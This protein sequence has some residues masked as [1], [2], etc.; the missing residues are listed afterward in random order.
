[1]VVAF[2][3]DLKA[4]LFG[5]PHSASPSSCL[6]TRRV[7]GVRAAVL[8]YF[9][10]DPEHFDVVFVANAT[11]AI[12]LVMHSFQEQKFSYRYHKDAHTSLV[13]IREVATAGSQ[14]FASNDDVEDWLIN[15]DNTQA[16]LIS[17]AADNLCLFAYP[18]QSNMTGHRLPLSWAS[19]LRQSRHASHRNAY[20]L[21]DA[22]S[23]LT[24]GR[25][26]LS[27]ASA[28]PDFI[29]LSFYKMFGFPD[30]GALI[31][32]KEAGGI[33]RSRRYF[34]GGTVDMVIDVN[35]SWHAMR[36]KELHEVLEDGTLPFHNIVALQHAMD[37]QKRIFGSAERISQHV[38][39]ISSHLYQA[40]V[41]MRHYNGRPVVH[42]Y[43]DIHSTYGDGN[44][45]GPIIAFNVLDSNGEWIGKS[46]FEKLAI[47]C[48]IQLRTGG[49]CNPGGIATMLQL[50]PWE[51][52]RNFCEGMRC[53]KGI[54]VSIF[55]AKLTN[56]RR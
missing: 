27:D 49:V 47:A 56:S 24:T 51:M 5:N 41:S 55:T 11:A 44:S 10:A 1:M 48:G 52:R 12:K 45:Q 9:K 18:A 31:V 21:L 19:D 30:L 29:T 15:G 6:S 26:D 14:C 38:S 7:D 20:S 50:E 17:E 13:G 2:A 54:Q 39:R 40:L 16:S 22:A 3:E 8:N 37:V 36:D 23:Y 35:E 32:R 25:L 43:Q 33:L 28:A 34:G 4:H 46:R 42:V 53:G